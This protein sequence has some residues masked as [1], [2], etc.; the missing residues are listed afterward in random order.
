MTCFDFMSQHPVL[1]IV[2]ALIAGFTLVG[3][4]EAFGKKQ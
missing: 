4:A 3:I 2:L 1:T